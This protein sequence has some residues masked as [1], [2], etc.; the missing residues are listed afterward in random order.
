MGWIAD[1]PSPIRYA[2]GPDTADDRIGG[3]KQRAPLAAGRPPPA[4]EDPGGTVRPV[5]ADIE[6]S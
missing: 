1:G 4:V 5:P 3:Q 6:E 2:K